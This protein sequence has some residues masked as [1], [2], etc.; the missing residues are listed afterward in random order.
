MNNENIISK[1]KVI[2]N[3]EYEKLVN[4]NGNLLIPIHRWFNIKEGYS[5]ALIKNLIR[6]FNIQ[7]SDLIMDPFTGSGTTL[8]A[9]K[10]KGINGIGFEI[11]P[12]LAFLTKLKL[13]DFTQEE[14]KELLEELKKI[15]KIN[16]KPS[17]SPP[18]LSISNK[19]FGNRLNEIMMLKEYILSISNIKKRDFLFL[20][21]LT[22]L[23]DVSIA[24]K[25]G[26]GLK[27]PKNK[28]PKEVLP[29]FISKLYTMI[30][31]LQF[32]DCSYVEN[33]LFSEDVRNLY[34]LINNKKNLVTTDLINNVNIDYI[35]NF[36]DKISLIVFS[37]PYMNCFDYTEVYKM[38]LWFGDF[39]KDYDELKILRNRS[40]VSHLNTRLEK[41]RLLNDRYINFFTSRI[42]KQKLWNRKIPLMIEGYFE[43]MWITLKGLYKLLKPGHYC[44]IVVGNSAY[45]NIAI[46]TDLILG[47]LGL[48]VGFTECK[49]EVARHLGTSSQQYKKVKNINFLRESLVILKK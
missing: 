16:F 41:R 46:P 48:K 15:K 28:M 21:L 27:Y 7:Q 13:T 1:I 24:K 2:K 40:L 17:I 26:N 12:F 43:D 8:L 30:Q 11:N 3:S 33:Y 9:A 4:F 29:T 14:R 19:L 18:K 34:D 45:G 32:S 38:E 25:D 39:I 35:K 31:D 22:I 20:A 37:P 23:E 42:N 44:V 36:N 10:E 49:I 5:K 47:N 6:R